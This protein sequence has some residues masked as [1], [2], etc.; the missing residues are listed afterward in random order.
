MKRTIGDGGINWNWYLCADFN[1]EER[2]AHIYYH[3]R[4]HKYEDRGSKHP[5]AEWLKTHRGFEL[6]EDQDRRVYGI[7]LEGVEYLVTNPGNIFSY[8]DMSAYEPEDSK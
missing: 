8:N 4:W 5:K 2:T 1:E 6:L 3:D 7:L